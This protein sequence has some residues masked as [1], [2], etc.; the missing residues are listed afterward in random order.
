MDLLLLHGALGSKRQMMPLQQRVGGVVIDFTGHGERAI[1]S[2]G[3]TFTQFVED[4]DR[5][6]ATNGFSKAHLFGYSMGGYAALLYAAQYPERVLSVTTLGSKL[7]WTEEGLQKELRMLDP[8][9]MEAKVPSFAKALG[10]VHGADRWQALVVAIAKSMSEL[11]AAPLLTSE[12]LSRIQCPV[13]LCVGE[14]DSTAVPEDTRSFATGLR[15][16]DVVVLPDTKHPFE[17]VDLG[18]LV[19]QLTRFWKSAER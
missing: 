10:E 9:K 2:T 5:A 19:P 12:V 1:P 7:V 15:N 3:L 13:L 18:A 6:Y 17:S 16:A 8:E 4:I 14:A 11:A